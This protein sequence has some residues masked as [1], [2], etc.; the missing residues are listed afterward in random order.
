MVI[1]NKVYIQPG[2][3]TVK[4]TIIKLMWAQWKPVWRLGLVEMQVLL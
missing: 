1:V 2:P 3:D 4:E